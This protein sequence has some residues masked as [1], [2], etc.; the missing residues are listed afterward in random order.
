MLALG[1]LLLRRGQVARC[2][3]QNLAIGV[4]F[5]RQRRQPLLGLCQFG[6]ERGGTLHQFRAT[7]LVV[8]TLG[9]STVG[10][11][12]EL[13]QALAVLANFGFDGVSAL[14]ALG[15]LGFGLLN[16][17]SLQTHLFRDGADL[18]VERG[19]L[20]LQLSKLAGQH[21]AQFGP[22]L[23]AQLGVALRLRSLA[24]Q[25]IH[26]PRDFFENVIHAG[27]VYLGV[28]QTRFRQ[29]LLGFELGDAGG[30]FDDGP[31][32]G[33]TA[34]QN[35]PD[36]SLL[37]QGIRF[38][39]QAGAHEQFLDIAQAAQ[40]SVQQIFAFAG[41]EQPPVYDDLSSLKLLLEL[42]AANL[43]NHLGSGVGDF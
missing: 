12:L 26:L 40:L 16:G 9:E 11:Q 43:Q 38:R 37:D 23:L 14:R 29:P 35:L 18:R 41:A 10:L 5:R 2:R 25:R 42:S 1:Q 8:T 31:A 15:V 19:A 27:Q 21:Q 17:F 22:H 34:A 13:A 39:P 32:I 7:F 24:L 6:L 36:A 20:L 33:G 4:A 3:V 30:F 28:F